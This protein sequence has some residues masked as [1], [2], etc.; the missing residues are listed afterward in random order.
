MYYASVNLAPI[1]YHNSE[2]PFYNAQKRVVGST[3]PCTLLDEYK[4]ARTHIISIIML[5]Y[6]CLWLY[7]YV[8]RLWMIESIVMDRVSDKI[9]LAQHEE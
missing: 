2:N 6:L 7:S 9:I 8:A 5:L 3:V 4:D 1:T